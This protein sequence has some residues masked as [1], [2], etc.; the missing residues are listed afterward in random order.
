MTD[1]DRLLALAHRV[2]A[3]YQSRPNLAAILLTGS[4][5]RGRADAVSDVDMT[6]YYDTLPTPDE[7]EAIQQSARD[8]GGGVYGYQADEGLACYHF[9]DGIKVDTAHTAVSAIDAMLAQ[10][11]Q[12]PPLAEPNQ[13]IVMSGIQQGIPLH[14]AAI[15]QRWQH[16]L[17][18]IDAPFFEAIVTAN[19]RF[20]P[21]AVLQ[22]MGVDRADYWLVYELLL[23]AQQRIMNLLC[24]LNRRIPPGKIKGMD[25]SLAG[26]AI[27]PAD[28]VARLRQ[29]W[30]LPPDT[31]VAALLALELEMLDLVDA[32]MPQV[33]T[34]PLRQRLDYVL[35]QAPVNDGGGSD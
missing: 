12:T 17:A 4:V 23:D 22:E 24:G 31:A 28:V 15:I 30:L 14:G 25:A 5:A 18:A 26:L 8:S 16:A 32:H 9:I 19:L 34:A 7:F 11:V 27:A 10:F 2:A 33:D 20:A 6:L 29:L 35:R 13:F 21:R 1:Q 3:G